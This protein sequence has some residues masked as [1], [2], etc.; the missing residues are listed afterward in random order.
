L[1]DRAT[2]PMPSASNHTCP[3]SCPGTLF[4]NLMLAR[5]PVKCRRR[6]GR[7]RSCR[8]AQ[9]PQPPPS[10]R[11]GP[12]SGWRRRSAA[13][14]PHQQPAAERQR[15]DDRS[16]MIRRSMSASSRQSHERSDRIPASISVSAAPWV[17][18]VPR[19]ARAARAA[20]HQHQC[21]HEPPALTLYTAL[22]TK[23]SRVGLES[24]TRVPHSWW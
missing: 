7:A 23:R 17:T 16:G 18:R 10:S 2:S 8:V 3:S 1:R 20:R 11:A 19:P 14:R 22:C 4:H 21:Q 15:D 12:N 5:A 9:L 6:N 24:A 13:P